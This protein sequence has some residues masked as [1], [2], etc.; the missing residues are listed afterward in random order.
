MMCITHSFLLT[1]LLIKQEFSILRFLITP[2]SAARADAGR[3]AYPNS[4]AE[5]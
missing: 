4:P 5:I 2:E 1:G 3:R